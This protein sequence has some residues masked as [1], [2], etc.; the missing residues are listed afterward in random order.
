MKIIA[1]ETHHIAVPFS[2]GAPVV[3]FAGSGWPSMNTLLVRVVTDQGLEGWGEAFG[4]ASCP[5]TRAVLDQQLAPLALGQDAR[6]IAGLHHRIGQALHVFGR[7]GPH[8]HALSGLDIALWD[9]AGRQAGLPLWRLLGASPA[10]SHRAY[11]SLLRYGDTTTIA[12]AVERAV[13]QGYGDLKLHEIAFE[14]VAAARAAAGVGPRIMLDTNC[15]WT[16]DQ[17]VAMA[18]RL[19]PLDLTWLEEPVW[20]PEDFAGIARVRREG[21]IPIAAG[22][23]AQGLMDFRAAFDAAA[24]DVAQPSVAKCGGITGM[25][26]IAGLAQARGVR[27]IPHCAYFGPGFLA[28]LHLHARLAPGEPFERLFMDLEAS[29]FHDAVVARGG[30]MAVPQG[31]GLG[32]VP[33]PAVL[34]RY[35]VSAPTIL[36]G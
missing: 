2:I 17:A 19:R 20:P 1:I 35:A 12:A 5:A 25:L 10:E 14:P 4:H 16:V 11:A 34:A 29:P 6:D 27:L 18:R 7:N 36:R 9:I 8:V 13:G 33:D 30:R 21:G 15:P 28:S 31:P 3:R 24:L 26:A 32:H 22:E 23:N